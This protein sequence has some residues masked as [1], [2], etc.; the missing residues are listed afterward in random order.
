[1]KKYPEYVK[2]NHTPNNLNSI[3]HSPYSCRMLY[4]IGVANILQIQTIVTQI[5][6]LPLHKMA[7]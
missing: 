5:V 1:M 4:F 2:Q 6:T 3:I 7:I